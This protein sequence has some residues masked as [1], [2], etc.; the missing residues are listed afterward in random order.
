MEVKQVSR[1]VDIEDV[2]KSY[3]LKLIIKGTDE[4][5]LTLPLMMY[6]YSV[7]DGEINTEINPSLSHGL[8]ELNAKLI[9]NFRKDNDEGVLS[10]IINTNN[11]AREVN[12]EINEEYLYFDS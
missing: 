5:N 7:V 6:F 2:E 9:K 10:L 3:I 4:F 1:N 8:A 12:I 11:G